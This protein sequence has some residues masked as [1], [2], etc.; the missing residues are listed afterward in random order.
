MAKPPSIV[1]ACDDPAW[2]PDP[3]GPRGTRS[4][5]E[6]RDMA[7]GVYCSQPQNLNDP[8]CKEQRARR[9]RDRQILLIGAA[10]LIALVYLND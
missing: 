1:T 8:W 2:K 7:E 6:C 5:R 4:R 10:V 9:M 3:N